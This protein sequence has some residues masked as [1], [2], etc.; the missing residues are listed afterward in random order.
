MQNSGPPVSAGN[1]SDPATHPSFSQGLPARQLRTWP[2]VLTLFFLAA[3]IPETIATY[4]SS[5][6]LLMTNPT[7]LLFISAFYGSIALLVRELIHRHHLRWASILL[8]G[9]AAGSLN[10]G[11]IA[12]TWYKVQYTGYAMINGVNPAVAVGLTVFHTLYS[13]VLPI[14]LVDLIFPRIA[15]NSWLNRKSMLF[16]SRMAILAEEV[17]PQRLLNW[18]LGHEQGKTEPVVFARS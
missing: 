14:L 17:Y 7:T 2:A 13:T 9:V 12:G 15:T 3:L 4:N 18:H 10:E 8:L 16:F 6:L 5:P 11:I 1:V